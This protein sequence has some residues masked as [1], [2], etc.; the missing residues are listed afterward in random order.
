MQASIYKERN[1]IKMKMLINGTAADSLSKETMKITA[2]FSGKVIDEVPKAGEEDIA[3]A[4]DGAAAAQKKWAKVPASERAKVMLAFVEL[5][6][7]Q[8]DS[9]AQTLCLDNGK[10][11]TQAKAELSN[12]FT[13]VPAFVEKYKHL[14]ETIIPAGSENAH[15][16]NLQ[17]V[18]RE[19]VGVVVCIIPFN[20]PSNLFCQKTI[21]ALLAGNSAVVLPPSGNPLTIM[22]LCHLLHEAGLPSGVLQ[23]VTA[24]GSLKEAAVTN[25]HTGL[26]TL[27]GSTQTGMHVAE[28]AARN[29]I[30]C[31]LELGGND[32]FI[33]MEDADMTK[34]IAELFVGRLINAGQICCASK[35]FLVHSSRVEEFT[36]RAAA[37]IDGL[38]QGDP[39][40]PETNIG[41]LI[42]EK[43]AK[44]VERQVE[45]T[46]RQGAKLVRGGK[47]EG[48][49]YAPTLLANVTP[50]MDIAKD[51]EV[52]GPV[53]PVI[54]FETEEEAVRIANQT[55]YGLSSCVFS[56][57]HRLLVKMAKALEAGNV[58]INGASNLRSF[59]MP[60]GGWKKS[61]IGTEGVMSTF[62]EMTRKKVIILKN[63][64]FF[65]D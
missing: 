48:A 45:L 31:A 16:R 29:L 5:V 13:A 51:M 41:C 3:L 8:L 18:V 26:V 9:L 33:V 59:E 34:V 52:F 27:T 60:F 11:F 1:E 43:A 53:I 14:Y 61:G 21:P 32:P 23:C 49:F 57:N 6:R 37:V 44:E 63:Y 64:D 47:R 24:P 12:L 7:E 28:I 39:M 38:K 20:F 42:N 36:A 55:M 50:E 10:P 2:P 46:C 19:P 22:R 4:M 25:E 54:S 40:L 65:T 58:I 30:P 56:E 62:E 17:A 35:R 15:A